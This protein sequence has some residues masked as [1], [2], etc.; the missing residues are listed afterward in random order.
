[1][2]A[3][4]RLAE[5]AIT[6]E[7][8]QLPN[9]RALNERLELLAAEAARGRRFSVAIIDIDHFKKVNDT[10][11]HAVGDQVL[12]AVAKT[13]R[14]SIRRSDMIARMGGEEFCVIQTDIDVDLMTML[15]E[16]LRVAI[17]NISEPL[18]VTASFG[19][20]HSSKTREPTALLH[21]SD[22]ALYAAK[23]GGRNRVVVAQ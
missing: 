15:T 18:S 8:T 3:Q 6:D 2:Q 21:Y 5:L 19:V 10:H 22:E 9:R 20:C 11:G 13:L 16:R 14:E 12:I 23:R 7:L 17:E 4:L 1:R